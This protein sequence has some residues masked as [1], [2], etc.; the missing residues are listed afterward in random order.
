MLEW[1]LMS[2]NREYLLNDGER[3][4][5]IS[6]KGKG[7][8]VV[9]FLGYEGE[10][11]EVYKDNLVKGKVKNPFKPTVC[12]VGII[13]NGEYNTKT[14][15]NGVN[16]YRLWV[17]MMQR[18]YYDKTQERSPTY[19][20]CSVGE[21]FIKY[22]EFAKW[23]FSQEF[24]SKSYQ[25]D[26]DL[27]IRDNKVYSPDTCCFLPRELNDLLSYRKAVNSKCLIGVTDNGKGGYVSK[28]MT[29]SEQRYLGTFNTPEEAFYAY[30]EAKEAYIKELANKYKD[31]IDPRAYEALINYEVSIDD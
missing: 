22:Q 11:H 8:V 27:L 16:I 25:L 3:C 19:K 26:K 31:K 4:R 29:N 5:I 24:I 7:K 14:S 15:I 28:I 9:E 21:V 12:G 1:F 23:C 13:G 30:K 17:R 18:S 10:S 6:V 20:G 2:E